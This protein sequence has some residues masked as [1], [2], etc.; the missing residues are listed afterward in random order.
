MSNAHLLLRAHMVGPLLQ[1][2]IQAVGS[3]DNLTEEDV[4]IMLQLNE[5]YGLL[6]KA[7]GRGVT[8]TSPRKLLTESG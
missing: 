7:L 3:E 8:S 1:A 2:Y 6:H 4:E 5:V